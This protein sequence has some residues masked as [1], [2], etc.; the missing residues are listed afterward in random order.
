MRPRLRVVSAAL[1]LAAGIALA[2]LVARGEAVPTRRP[3]DELAREVG[4]YRGA[5]EELEPGVLAALGVTDVV[6]RRYAAAG[7]API[8]LYAGFYATQRTGAIIHSPRQCLPGNGWSILS[9]ERVALEPGVL[10]NRVLVAKGEDRQVVVYWYQERGRVVAS[11]YWGKAYLVW[12]SMTRR[13]SDGALV[14]VSA[15]VL[16]DEAAVDREVMD[17][18]RAVLPLLTEFLPA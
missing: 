5:D 17:F 15:P 2:Q 6:M 9:A 11:E 1:V 10:V 3:L 16:G 18:S 14:R 7:R 4:A 8:V 13:R 12:D